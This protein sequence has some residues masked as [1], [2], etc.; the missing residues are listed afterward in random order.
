MLKTT[1][2][3]LYLS[4]R[5]GC[6]QLDWFRS[7]HTFNFGP[8]Q[9]EGRTPFGRLYTVNDDTL[10][11]GCGLS[12][13][14]EHDT[15]VLLLPLVGGVEVNHS[16]TETV[17]ASAGEMLVLAVR[18]H[19]IFSITNPYETALINYLQIWLK[20]TDGNGF[21]GGC[22]GMAFDI[23]IRNRLHEL[24]AAGVKAYIGQF[25]GRTEGVVPVLEPD[26]GLFAFVIEG[27]FEVQNRLMHARDGLALW[28]LEEVEFEA[29]SNDALIL[30][31]DV[32]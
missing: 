1:E 17:F 13:P 29:L 20:A 30:F 12:I 2:G 31:A 21:V 19:T 23:G 3:Q 9:A 6:S 5:R 7:L 15:Y 4:D 25:D 22:Q 11:P 24:K 10:N 18:R 27:A 8:Y 28:S 26:K 16:L 14:V 32:A